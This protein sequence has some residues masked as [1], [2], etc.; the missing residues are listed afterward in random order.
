MK[1]ISLL[2][3]VCLL[4]GCCAVSVGAASEQKYYCDFE[5]F[6]GS[7]DGQTVP[8]GWAVQNGKAGDTGLYPVQTKFGTS[9]RMTSTATQ[10][11]QMRKNISLSGTFALELKILLKDKNCDRW[12]TIREGTGGH[13]QGVVFST[14]G[15]VQIDGAAKGKWKTDV[16]YTVKIL[17]SPDTKKGMTFVDDGETVI[18][19]TFTGKNVGQLD[20]FYITHQGAP[21]GTTNTYVDNIK[22]STET[23][24][25]D[26]TSG[27][28]YLFDD[29]NGNE[30]GITIS[31][32]FFM[33]NYISN[34][35]NCAKV[36]PVED[37][38]GGKSLKIASWSGANY[39]EL[40]HN[41]SGLTTPQIITTDVKLKDLNIQRRSLG[42]RAGTGGDNTIYSMVRFVS[43][44]KTIEIGV[45]E[46]VVSDLNTIGTFDID[47]WYHIVLETDPQNLTYKV[48]VTDENGTTVTG[49]ADLPEG[50]KRI[51]M[52]EFLMR[53]PDSNTTKDNNTVTYLDNINIYTPCKPAL[54]YASPTNG[55][56]NVPPNAKIRL[57]FNKPMDMN[58]FTGVTLNGET[59]SRSDFAFKS[60]SE[61]V[62]T[63]SEGFATDTEY[64]LELN[65]IKDADGQKA[66]GTVSFRTADSLFYIGNLV[67]DADK[68]V[69]HVSEAYCD[70]TK[71]MVLWYVVTEKATGKISEIQKKNITVTDKTTTTVVQPSGTIDDTKSLNVLLWDGADTMNVV[72]PHA[73]YN[74]VTVK[75]TDV[76]EPCKAKVDLDTG[77]L[78]IRGKA[79]AEQAVTV[80]VLKPGKTADDLKGDSFAD[81]VVYLAE[82]ESD[83]NGLYGFDCTLSGNSGKF[84]ISVNYGEGVKEM[85]VSY[86]SAEDIAKVL[87]A[88]NADGADYDTLI[89]ENTDMLGLDTADYSTT[90]TTNVATYLD[91]ARPFNTISEFTEDFYIGVALELLGKAA[92]AKTVED[93]V[94]KYGTYLKID[95]L[96][97]YET[98]AALADKTPVF[99][100]IASINEFKS[101]KAFTDA[102]TEK[103]ILCTV[104][105]PVHISSITAALKDNAEFIGIS[106]TEWQN[107]QNSQ[108]VESALKGNSYA[109]M[110]ELKTAFENAVTAQQQAEADLP[111]G[112]N[113]GGGG[114]S[115]PPKGPS[116]GSI[117]I[118]SPTTA[119]VPTP[120][121]APSGSKTFGDIDHVS[122]AREAIEYLAKKGIVNG[123]AD[124]VFAPD[125]FVTREEFVKLIAEAFDIADSSEPMNFADVSP[126]DWFCKYLSAA[127]SAGIVSGISDTHFGAGTN[128]SRQDMAV[129]VYRAAAKSGVTLT[130]NTQTAFDDSADIAAYALESVQAM[131]N[132]GI[133]NGSGNNCFSPLDL[134][135]RAQA[136]KIIYAML[137]VKGE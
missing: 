90:D 62:F 45:D 137:T 91:S 83:E 59:V 110:A 58:S 17:Y 88:L 54:L 73:S 82:T 9:V 51:V 14:N 68:S 124:G 72:K 25:A 116:V 44:T 112:G 98:Y 48:S 40:R 87:E 122:W 13:D 49:T 71:N 15:E 106:T 77:K 117:D 102:L 46:N 56:T 55:D 114:G 57:L 11:F 69:T 80:A 34:G 120:T 130:P 66:E 84:G 131:A 104:Q 32:D 113:S 108:K 118:V 109:N 92:D 30:D 97:V 2:L 65:G 35:N 1:K 19:D 36:E 63:P 85:T 119:P 31:N 96:P 76:A 47:V 43:A 70:D 38:R 93:V 12:I 8:E 78:E 6:A 33:T 133:I 18:Y 101:V 81:A 89:T 100:A 7:A 53:I 26:L 75:G 20:S 136:A 52:Y 115:K 64:K 28:S 134:A 61:C 4:L 127:Y 121:A 37:N 39:L 79:E 129:M 24:E 125:D 5:T 103:S 42:L 86:Y 22:L 107:L 29:F 50:L 128:I 99:S 60:A 135:T 41:L 132:S 27:Q 16:W 3:V 21:T 126:N 67:L 111:S 123:K 94:T 74:G 95:K 105:S 10:H 23:T